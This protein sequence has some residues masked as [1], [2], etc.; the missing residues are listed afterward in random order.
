M[1]KRQL[2][3]S[4]VTLWVLAISSAVFGA[5]FIVAGK[6][7]RG[8]RIARVVPPATQPKTV[9]ASA[10]ALAPVVGLV[11]AP[12]PTRRVVVRRSRAS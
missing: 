5:G 3:R 9:P 2:R 10:R 6:V 1:T 8:R 7:D 11:P 12:L 4:V